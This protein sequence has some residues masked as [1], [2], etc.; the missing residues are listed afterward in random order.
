MIYLNKELISKI[1]KEF[2]QLNIQDTHNP[3]EKWERIC[4]DIFP[5]KTYG[6][7]TGP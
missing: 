7:P 4:T 2:I 1:Y 5:K 3:I 6:W